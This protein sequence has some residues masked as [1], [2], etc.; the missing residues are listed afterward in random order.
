VNLIL[1]TAQFGL[2]YG[3][4][5]NQ[6]QV[7]I[8]AAKA[9]M[10]FAFAQGIHMLDT[11]IAYGDCEQRLGRIGVKDWKVVSKLP[12]I[13]SDCKDIDRFVFTSIFESL[14]R[15][16]IDR[17]YG[18]LLHRP[19]QLNSTNGDILYKSLLQLKCEGVI[20]KIGVS[21]YEPLEVLNFIDRYP[22]DLIQSPFS[23]LD[24]RLVDTGGIALFKSRG[25]EV[26]VRSIFLQ[27]LLLMSNHQRPI[28]FNRWRSVWDTWHKWL[29]ECGLSPLEACLR[30]VLKQSQVDGVVVGVTTLEQLQSILQISADDLFELPSALKCDDRKLINPANWKNLN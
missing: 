2:D 25:I 26:H 24:N 15:L 27:G 23:V 12:E 9:I 21:I 30:H 19:H 28:Q 3:I 8:E 18:L 4:S 13:P 11:A 10:D 22:I 17:L 7:T 6:G 16:K 1:G 20:T 14:H 29:I 5:N